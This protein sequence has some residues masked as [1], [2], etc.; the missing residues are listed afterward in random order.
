MDFHL[1]QPDKG[2][3]EIIGAR[4]LSVYLCDQPWVCRIHYIRVYVSLL[5]VRELQ[6]LCFCWAV[7]IWQH[8]TS[9]A[10]WLL[11]LLEI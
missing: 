5:G 9:K 8:L 1:D 11:C 2:T 6:Q 4:E 7:K 10:K 3:D